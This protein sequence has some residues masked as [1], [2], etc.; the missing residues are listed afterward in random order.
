MVDFK[1]S[2]VRRASVVVNLPTQRLAVRRD[3]QRAR[4]VTIATP[5]VS[6]APITNRG[7]RER[8]SATPYPAT[9]THTGLCLQA[10]PPYPP[11]VPPLA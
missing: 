10:R 3:L 4:G 9:D 2:R 8:H 11:G 6:A 7:R 5:D 1:R